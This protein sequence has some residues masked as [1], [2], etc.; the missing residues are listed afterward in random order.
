MRAKQNR[1]AF[2]K[3]T[4]ELATPPTKL[5]SPFNF[6][7]T[8]R[9]QCRQ[10]QQQLDGSFTIEEDV[11]EEEKEE[12]EKGANKKKVKSSKYVAKSSPK[13]RI[14]SKHKR[15]LINQFAIDSPTGRLRET[16]RDVEKFQQCIEE[17]SEAIHRARDEK[18]P[19]E[20]KD[21]SLTLR[22]NNSNNY[23]SNGGPNLLD[24]SANFADCRQ[25][26]LEATT[27]ATTTDELV[28][29]FQ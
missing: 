22:A 21:Q 24:C 15:H 14:A 27:S 1:Q 25:S 11:E 19:R 5:Y 9:Q 2:A 6:Y 17:I 12:R 10:Q 4:N 7:N 13:D 28:S 23:A 3:L 29:F 20:F 16:V 18:N 26:P 8:P